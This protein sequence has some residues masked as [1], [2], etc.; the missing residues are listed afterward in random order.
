MWWPT[1]SAARRR[2]IASQASPS[3]SKSPGADGRGRS[4]RGI[5]RLLVNEKTVEAHISSIFSKL[6]LVEEPNDHRRVLAVRAWLTGQH[7]P[8]PPDRSQSRDWRTRALPCEA[9]AAPLP[10]TGCLANVTFVLAGSP[11]TLMMPPWPLAL[12]NRGLHPPE[13]MV[14]ILEAITSLE[15]SDELCVLM[16]REPLLLYP[17]SNGAASSGSSR[18]S[19]TDSSWSSGR[20]A[21]WTGSA[22]P[23]ARRWGWWRRSLSLPHSARLLRATH[24]NPFRRLPRGEHRSSWLRPTQL[25]SDG[26]PWG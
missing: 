25:S 20:C 12:D 26:S 19:T 14:R 3:A 4:N 24:D 23:T 21:R 9:C 17:S 8:A 1:S 13:P 22:R 18:H 7:L 11:S 6:S 2:A 16:D 10:C 5:G 15:P